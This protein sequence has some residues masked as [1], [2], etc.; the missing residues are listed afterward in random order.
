MDKTCEGGVKLFVNVG[1]TRMTSRNS[2]GKWALTMNYRALFE[3]NTGNQNAP[4]PDPKM[5]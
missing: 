4:S 5:I 2:G 1:K 3:R